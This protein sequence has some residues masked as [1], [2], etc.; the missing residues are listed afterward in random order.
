[1]IMAHPCMQEAAQV[2]L[3]ERDEKVQAFMPARP[4]EPLTEGIRLGTPWQRV[5]D[6]QPQVVYR[7]VKQLGEDRIAVMDEEGVLPGHPTDQ[8]LQ[9]SRKRRSSRCGCP[10]PAEAK[11]LARPAD[12]CGWLGNHQGL[13]PVDASGKPGEREPSGRG[14]TLG[15]DV[16]LLIQGQRFP[17]QEMFRG[18][19]MG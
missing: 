9:V 8:R 16:A 1:V 3:G 2:V 5:E 10:S 14:R 12:H 17:Q 6:L 15:C 13:S 7:L 11:A 18:K 4:Q 19:G